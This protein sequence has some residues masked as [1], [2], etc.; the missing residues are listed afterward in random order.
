MQSAHMYL[1]IQAFY[2]EDVDGHLFAAAESLPTDAGYAKSCVLHLVADDGVD[3]AGIYV[4]V[5]TAT[6]PIWSFIDPSGAAGQTGYSAGGVTKGDLVYISGWNT[7]NDIPAI[8]KADASDFAKFATHVACETI[9]ALGT[10]RIDDSVLLTALDTSSYSVGDT[11]YAGN[12]AG[13]VT[14]TGPTGNKFQ[15]RVGVV[16]TAHA[17]TGSIFFSPTMFARVT[18]FGP[19]MLQGADDVAYP[20]GGGPD[21]NLAWDNSNGVAEFKNQTAGG[22]GYVAIGE[23]SNSATGGIS[24][25]HQTAALKV[26]A[27]DDGST[28]ITAASRAIWGRTLLTV[29]AG[30]CTMDGVLGQV[31]INVNVTCSADFSSGVRGY[32][33]LKGANTVFTGGANANIGAGGAALRGNISVDTSLTIETGHYLC[34]LHVGLNTASGVTITQTGKLVGVGVF[35]DDQAGGATPTDKWGIGVFI[36]QGVTDTAIQIGEQ[37]NTAGSGHLVNNTFKR[38][39]AIFCDDNGVGTG[40]AEFISTFRGRLLVTGTTCVGEQYAVHGTTKYISSN[41]GGWSGG[42]LGT[43]EWATALTVSGGYHGAIFA[44]VGGG[45]VGPAIS[46][47]AY[48][49]GVISASS[50]AAAATGS[51]STAAFLAGATNVGT[52]DWDFGLEIVSDTCATGIHV[53]TCSSAALT[54]GVAGTDGGD[55]L[56]YTDDTG[57]YLQYDT[58]TGKFYLRGTV[59]DFQLAASGSA[60]GSGVTLSATKT[61]AMGVY[62]DDGAAAISSAT[63]IRAGRF[64]TLMSYLG[65]REDEAAGLEGQLVSIGGGTNRHNKCGLMGTYEY[66][67]SASFIIDGQIASTDAWIQAGVIG[68]VDMGT[69]KTTVNQYGVLAGV[70]AMSIT[71]SF[72]TNNGTYAAFYAGAWDSATDWTHGLY[73]EG[74]KCTTGID[75]GTCTSGIVFTG[76]MTTGIDFTAATIA[77]ASART[78]AAII[79]GDRAGAKTVTMAGGAANMYLDLVQFNILIAGASPDA[80]STVNGFYQLITHSTAMA[81]IRLKCADWNIAVS[82]NIKDAYIYQGQMDF[83]SSGV[84]VGG[85]A[86]VMGL[87]MNAGTSAVSGLLRGLIISMEGLGFP[88]AGIGLEIRSTATTLAEGI[89]IKSTPLITVGIVM[90]D[91]VSDNCGPTHAFQFPSGGGVYGADIG[92]VVDTVD[93]GDGLGSI[94]IK[95]GSTTRYLKYWEDPS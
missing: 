83:S 12:A 23:Y 41:A 29:N 43:M 47:G 55:V 73:I 16:V 8:T 88:A 86:A 44:R 13:S 76:T 67:G 85:E 60:S 7:A 22:V 1:P 38:A 81:N 90:C 79:I 50:L 5:G 71:P 28:G 6:T 84:T 91:P 35:A 21:I 95:I 70:A 54:L 59:S 64:R 56:V 20:I 39:V 69:S 72:S 25:E 62:A 66:S 26:Y 10:G 14:A 58:G 92:P 48:L 17:T 32:L 46:A 2:S 78:N 11:L 53:G 27:D 63:F 36:H 9:A 31:K 49:A 15:Q 80:G 52:T 45:A 82:A 74:G 33:E 37:S 30:D 3:Q 77:P 19:G 68:R 24:L 65:N 18:K 34:G 94:K 4:N 57:S 40:G 87:V 51:G 42:I 61:K 93:S 89:R 75:I